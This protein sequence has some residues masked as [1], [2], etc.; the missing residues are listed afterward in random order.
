M[1]KLLSDSTHYLRSE[2]LAILGSI[3]KRIRQVRLIDLSAI[4]SLQEKVRAIG[5]SGE[6]AI[7]SRDD[8]CLMQILIAHLLTF[9]DL[10]VNLCSRF[11][12]T[13]QSCGPSIMRRLWDCDNCRLQERIHKG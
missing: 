4:E 10:S 2:S 9:T 1:Q 12:A 6:E 13:I 8:L 7:I 11:S 3:D 5:I